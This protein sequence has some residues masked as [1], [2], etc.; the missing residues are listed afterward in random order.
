MASVMWDL[1][2]VACGFVPP[3]NPWLCALKGFTQTP[4]NTWHH[5]RTY[6]LSDEEF[7]EL[8]TQYAAEGGFGEQVPNPEF[9]TG[10]IALAEA[11]FE[12]H[13]VTDRPAIAEAD[14]AWWLDTFAPDIDSLTISRDK[15]VFT[16]FSE[17]PYY[18]I[19]D[20]VENVQ[21]MIEGGVRAFLLTAPWNVDAN[22][23]R[24]SSIGEFVSFVTL[25]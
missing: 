6:G 3:F 4:W 9:I 16:T 18:A 14:T 17:G 7:V 25:T 19:D 10:V 23:P 24:V 22:L 21:A 11:G 13:V 8:L 1:D 2:G 15:T 12:Q 5:Y 20:R